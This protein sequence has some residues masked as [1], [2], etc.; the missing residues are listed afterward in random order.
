MRNAA[1]IVLMSCLTLPGEAQ[2]AQTPPS[3]PQSTISARVVAASDGQPL[4]HARVMIDTAVAG[5]VTVT[6]TDA[7]GRFRMRAGAAP[8]HAVVS[9]AGFA[10]ADVTLAGNQPVEIR[11]ARAGVITGRATDER[12]DPIVGARVIVETKAGNGLRT[13]A[14]TDTDDRGEYRVAPLRAGAFTV[15]IVTVANGTA[16]T[17]RGRFTQL[18]L[19][20]LRLLQL[21]SFVVRGTRKIYYPGVDVPTGDA[22][23]DV[24][25][26]AERTADFVLPA[27]TT[28]TRRPGLVGA[29]MMLARMHLPGDKAPGTAVVRGRVNSTDGRPL[30]GAQVTLILEREWT[31]RLTVTTGVS[32]DFEFSGV[33]AG[34]YHREAFK[35]GYS[36]PGYEAVSRP[37]LSAADSG[38]M[39]EVRD[40]ENRNG[41]DLTLAPWAAL[42]GRLLDEYGE[43]LD[44]AR[45]RLFQVRYQAGRRGLVQVDVG[46]ASTDDRGVYR[47]Y[48]VPPGQYIVRASIGDVGTA[49]IPGYVPSYFPG[50]AVVAQARYV[51]LAQSEEL[52]GV[53]FALVPGHTARIA[54]RLLDARGRPTSGGSVQLLPSAASSMT[55]GVASGART[56]PDGRFEFVNVPPGR[57]VIQASRGRLASWAEGEFGSWPVLVGNGDITGLV[58][59][60]SAGSEITGEVSFDGVA[61]RPPSLPAGMVVSPVATDPDQAPPSVAA[62]DVAGD[63]SFR[64]SG[65]TGPRRL[66]VMHIPRGWGLKQILADGVDVTDRTLSFGEARQSLRHVEVVLTDR[67]TELAG[68]VTSGSG[69]AVS[70]MRVIVFPA[71]RSLWYPAS[72]FIRTALTPGDGGFAIEGLPF[73][74]YY[75]AA[76]AHVAHGDRPWEDPDLLEELVPRAR[77]VTLLEGQRL[78]L[79]LPLRDIATPQ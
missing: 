21:S 51:A 12:G 60:A 75:V 65:V 23:V 56:F 48:G 73:G 9:K 19:D 29:V 30:A 16:D 35:S 14:T 50:T 2:R 61:R 8:R 11:M 7:D 10:P 6:R 46:P 79:E 54:G 28:G 15:A 5:S 1:T 76:V 63:G 62:A 77:L 57:Y 74:T 66:E 13:V 40:G 42:T 37:T 36:L 67:V 43:P 47:L 55:I 18:P 59:Q 26:G 71:D 53:D 49:N 45:V 4:A 78:S 34:A 24:P 52:G 25:P 22:F 58:L 44:H 69:R 70:G 41:A 32:G 39:L 20:D 3:P 27:G 72:R 68:H 38:P 33:R 17:G 64:I 31:E